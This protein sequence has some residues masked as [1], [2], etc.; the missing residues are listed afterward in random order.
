MFFRERA[1]RQE[2]V[3]L[4]EVADRALANEAELRRKAENRER[5]TQAAFLIGRD[6]LSAADALMDK[7]TDLQPSLEAESVLRRLGEWHVMRNDWDRAA[8]RFEQLL[9]ADQKDK[10][11]MITSDLLM[12]G[13][14]QIERGD[15]QGYEHF[16]RA[17]IARF[18]G[19]DNPIDAERTLKISLLLPADDDVMKALEPFDRLAAD[20]FEKHGDN[21]GTSSLMA[22][23]RCV[24]LALMAYRQNYTPT[25]KEWCRKCLSYPENT[26][27]RIATAH[28]IR[29]M[30]AHKLGEVDESRTELA[31]G[32]KMIEAEFADGLGPGNGSLGW[33]YDWLFARVLL[34]E[35]EGLIEPARSSE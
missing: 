30:A 28:V 12:A 18:A 33:W 9:Q 32:R 34:R 26:P 1:A 27:A 31:A 7:I 24:S 22:A 35:A 11:E 29:A 2:Q 10:S 20:S 14:I 3:R 5:I 21:A 13:P 17:A 25:A 16:R 6:E 19:T 4:R 15:V 23:W 8:A